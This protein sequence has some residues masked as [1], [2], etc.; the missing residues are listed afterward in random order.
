MIFESLESRRLFAVQAGV[1]GGVLLVTGDD[2]PNTIVVADQGG[3]NFLVAGV[4]GPT[5]E[6]EEVIYGGVKVGVAVAAGL[7]DDQVVYATDFVGASPLAIGAA[8]SL[9]AGDDVVT[10]E[11]LAAG[12]RVA[13]DGGAGTDLVD[14]TAM[15]GASVAF[16][17]GADSDGGGLRAFAG[18]SVYVSGGA[19]DDK[20]SGTITGFLLNANGGTVTYDGGT[21][22]DVVTATTLGAGSRFV[23]SGGAGDDQFV[24][25]TVVT[26]AVGYVYG[27]TGNDTIGVDLVEGALSATDAGG[28][29][30]AGQVY[31]YGENGNDTVTLYTVNGLAYVY[32]GNGADTIALGFLVVDGTTVIP[33]SVGG[34]AHVTVDGGSGF[35]VLQTFLSK[36]DPRLTLIRVERVVSP[37]AV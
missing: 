14:A 8:L 6:D 28:P 32:S 17:G 3:G 24:G 19:G 9:G 13:V 27:G 33:G 11:A 2:Q 25:L 29:V 12:V 10:V 20:G 4:T 21:G 35:D 31:V 22:D 7:G 16:A 30:A 34:T 1:Y 18:S 5:G 26:G 15:N 37:T 36:D 23:L